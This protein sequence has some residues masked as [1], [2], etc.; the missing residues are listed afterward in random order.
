M[1]KSQRQRVTSERETKRETDRASHS[2]ERLKRDHVGFALLTRSVLTKLR[3]FF[4]FFVFLRTC[5]CSVGAILVKGGCSPC[6]LVGWET[7]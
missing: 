2:T 6:W 3:S 7:E 1:T 4:I 5:C